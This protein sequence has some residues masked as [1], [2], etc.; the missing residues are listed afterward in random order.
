MKRK[1]ILLAVF[2][3]TFFVLVASFPAYALEN[4]TGIFKKDIFP[5]IIS[6]EEIKNGG[7]T[8]R[9]RDKE[10]DLY[11]MVFKNYQNINTIRIFDHPVKYVNENGDITDISLS[12][13]KNSNGDFVPLQHEIKAI[14]PKSLEDGIQLEHKDL[15][16]KM[17][18]SV[19]KSSFADSVDSKAVTYKCENK[20]SYEY[21]LTYTGFKEDIIVS[22]YTGQTEYSFVLY[23][24]GL[25][26]LKKHNSYFLVDELGKEKATIGD[27]IV[28]TNDEKN[29]TYGELK[30]DELTENE[31]YIITI[32][33]DSSFLKSVDTVYPIR[34]DPTIEYVYSGAIQDLTINS[35]DNI[36]NGTSGSIFAGKRQ[37]YGKSR[38]LM[39]FPDFDYT[40]IDDV[41]KVLTATVEIRDLMCESTAATV[42]CYCC[43]SNWNEMTTTWSSMPSSY[44]GALCDSNVVSYSNGLL[45]PT[46]HRYSF[47]ITSAFKFWKTSPGTRNW[48]IVF[49]LE[50]SVE[51]GLTYLHKTFASYNR[52]SYKPSLT[53]KYV[54]NNPFYS[55]YEPTKFNYTGSPLEVGDFT[56]AIQ[57]RMGTYGYAFRHIYNDSCTL[58]LDSLDHELYGYRQNIGDFSDISDPAHYHFGFEFPLTQYEDLDGEINDCLFADAENLGYTIT[59]YIPSLNNVAQ[60]G[61]HSRL[62]A[63]VY[64]EVSYDNEPTWEFRFIMYMQHNDGTWSYKKNDGPVTNLSVISHVPLTNANIREKATEGFRS[65]V[66][67]FYEITRPAI[68]DYPHGDFD[69]ENNTIL[70]YKDV[71]G[72]NI[73]TASKVTLGNI[74]CKI[75]FAKDHDVFWFI[76]KYS[77]TYTIYTTCETSS[78][79]DGKIM[80][81]NGSSLYYDSNIGQI[82][83]SIY[84]NKNTL[85]YIEI[86]NYSETVSDYTLTIDY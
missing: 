80:N 51:N 76:P 52:A 55:I 48:G 63:V 34:I 27:I 70:Y 65:P 54:D 85:Y 16:I 20:T 36:P 13:Q 84:L 64:G 59:E 49:K 12:L 43:L 74:S 14:F 79:I 30:V 38:I 78:D 41:D 15:S 1:L 31:I 25:S 9:V 26:V 19:K 69:T 42:L 37:T 44:L 11:T 46:S 62:V 2:T 77:S 81:E 66:I 18:P 7:Y 28:F 68:I 86:Y 56:D 50:D 60:F 32:L 8:E 33:L 10:H 75:D 5:D 45:Q 53:V 39:K 47:D 73:I 4:N 29:N 61:N 72:E 58:E 23:T 83:F 40:I 21:S 6:T 82:Y 3:L 57:Y 22:E 24:N 71:A 17:I 35:D 67:V